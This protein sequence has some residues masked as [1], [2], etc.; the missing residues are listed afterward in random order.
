MRHRQQVSPTTKQ[1]VEGVHQRWGRYGRHDSRIAG[2]ERAHL[3]TPS[4]ECQ[5]QGSG[6]IS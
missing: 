5:G 2:Q 6:D 4:D 3:N 1:N